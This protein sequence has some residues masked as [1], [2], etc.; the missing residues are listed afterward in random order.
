MN[1]CTAVFPNTRANTR[2]VQYKSMQPQPGIDLATFSIRGNHL[3]YA[4]TKG[5]NGLCTE[6]YEN[7]CSNFAAN[8]RVVTI[9]MLELT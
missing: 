3:A 6:T 5:I 8:L 4:A 9:K 1:S 7:G 2:A